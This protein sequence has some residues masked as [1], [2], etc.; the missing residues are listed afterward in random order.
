MRGSLKITMSRA[1]VVPVTLCLLSLV[2]CQHQAAEPPRQAATVAPE[3]ALPQTIAFEQEFTGEPLRTTELSAD[4][5]LETFAEGDGTKAAPGK[6]VSFHFDGYDAATGDRVMGT[7]EWPVKLV[8]GA[9]PTEP[10]GV[11]MQEVIAEQR[12]GARVRVHVPAVVANAG[13]PAQEPE[14][15]DLWITLTVTDVDD[16]QQPRDVH[17][18]AGEPVSSWARDGLEIYDFAVGEGLEASDGDRVEFHY[19]IMSTEGETLLSTH[20][21][22]TPVELT[23]GPN[24]GVPGLGKGLR[25][26]K[27]GTLRKLVVPAEL[28]FD[29]YA[30]EH[31]PRDVAMVMYIEITRVDPGPERQ[32]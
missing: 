6:R 20:A 2:G 18:F 4:V 10:L 27:P 24:T 13:R 25:G 3:P 17:A 15:G 26:A 30:P 21:D 28:G 31:F 1:I 12:P 8:V 11:I 14:L 9:A 5:M 19:V 22:A 7:Q 32:I 29:E 16:P 23:I